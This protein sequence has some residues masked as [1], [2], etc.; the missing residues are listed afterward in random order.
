[1]EES[2]WIGSGPALARAARARMG[3]MV[4]VEERILMGKRW[5]G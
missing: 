2:A 5:L 4:N 3:R 1:M